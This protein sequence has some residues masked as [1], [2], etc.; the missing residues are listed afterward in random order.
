MISLSS[1]RILIKEELGFTRM[2]RRRLLGYGGTALGIGLAGCSVLSSDTQEGVFLEQV[3]LGNGSDEPQVF[4]VLVKNAEDILHWATY[5][6]EPRDGE[7][8]GGHLVE[9]DSSEELRDLQ[10]FVRVGGNWQSATFDDDRYAGEQ[11]VAVVTYGQPEAG[12]LRISRVEADD[13]N[14]E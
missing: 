7:E 8:L 13:S 5:E 14:T 10:I 11:V 1:Y 6:V 12:V 4:D 9:I 3:E 2:K